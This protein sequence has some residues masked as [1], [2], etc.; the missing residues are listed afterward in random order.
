M[1]YDLSRFLKAQER[2]YALA[3]AE[4]RAGRKRSHWMW[5]VFPQLRGLGHSS[6]ADFYGLADREEA[7]QYLAAPYW[8]RGCGSSAPRCFLCPRATPS[9]SWE[10][11]TI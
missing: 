9:A 1:R 8:G 6:L 2:D 11:R 5:Y 7:R 4:I 10:G 3:L